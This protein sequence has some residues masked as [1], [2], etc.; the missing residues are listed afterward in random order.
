[1]ANERLGDTLV[2]N[3]LISPDQLLEAQKAQKSNGSRLGSQLVKLGYITDK[4]LVDFLSQ[5]YGVPPIIL[6]EVNPDL[7][8]VKLIPLNVVQ[9]YMSIPFARDGSALKVAMTDPSN[10]FAIDDLKFLTGYSIKVYVTSEK[11]LK[12]AIDNFYDRSATLDDALSEIEDERD[13]V[14][15]AEISEEISA[16]DLEKEADQAP[17]I[18]LVTSSW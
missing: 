7:E 1:M 18:K 12:W 14:E 17:V 3:A 4:Q 5:Q 15:I 6:N 11:S 10:I 8:V 13:K 2:K 9:K 16:G